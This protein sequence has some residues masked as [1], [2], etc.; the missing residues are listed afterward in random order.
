MSSL[1][2]QSSWG[3][4]NWA[5]PSEKSCSIRFTFTNGDGE[6]QIISFT[7]NE[8]SWEPYGYIHPEDAAELISD[9]LAWLIYSSNK[10]KVTKFRDMILSK[11][12]EIELGNKKAELESLIKQ[13]GK[14]EEQIK[15]LQSS[16][17]RI[18]PCLKFEPKG[19][20]QE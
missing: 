2:A 19:G 7:L 14:I 3:H 5:N 11:A 16:I 8:P 15:K 20:W 10:E 12:D 9:W 4:Y 18:E 17:K 13:K 1:Y 6:K